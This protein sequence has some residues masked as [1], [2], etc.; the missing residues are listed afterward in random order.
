MTSPIR[1]C[2]NATPSAVRTR[3]PASSAAR[4]ASGRDLEPLEQRVRGLPTGRGEQRERRLIEALDARQHRF[5][6]A[7]GERVAG[8][9]QLLDEERVA[10][11]ARVQL[12]RQRGRDRCARDRL[13]LTCDVLAAERLELDPQDRTP[14]RELRGEPSQLARQASST[15]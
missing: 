10:A 11:G 8:G 2:R 3:T 4:S 9:E 5:R 14:A 15:R 1:P 12:A 7:P 6:D 13:Q